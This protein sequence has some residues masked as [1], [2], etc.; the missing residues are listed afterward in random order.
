SACRRTSCVRSAE[1]PRAC[2]SSTSRRTTRSFRSP[3][4]WRKKTRRRNPGRLKIEDWRFVMGFQFQFQSKIFILKSTIS[5]LLLTAACARHGAEQVLLDQFFNASRLRDRTALQKISTVILEPLEQG[6]VTTFTITNVV[7][8][9]GP[10]G[11][12]QSKEVN[13]SAPVRL[14]DGRTVQK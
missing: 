12:V 3:G 7:D 9:E 5:M 8:V 2:G 6:A 1:R 11:V 10:K 14:P 4:S 13:V